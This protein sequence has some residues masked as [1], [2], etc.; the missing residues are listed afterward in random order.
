MWQSLLYSLRGEQGCGRTSG[1]SRVS[2]GWAHGE[3]PRRW[4]TD[5]ETDVTRFLPCYS[6]ARTSVPNLVHLLVSPQL[7]D[8]PPLA[9]SCTK[10]GFPHA[11]C[12]AAEHRMLRTGPCPPPAAPK[13]SQGG[14]RSTHLS[15]PADKRLSAGPCSALARPCPFPGAGWR[16]WCPLGGRAA[17]RSPP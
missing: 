6:I 15:S 14:S 17:A 7:L 4:V 11:R 13:L 10:P 9:I 5:R 12:H 2:P 3:W 16:R 8:L 1:G